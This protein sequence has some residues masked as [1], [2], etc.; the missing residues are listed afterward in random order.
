MAKITSTKIV[1]V[2]AFIGLGLVLIVLL[3]RL[4]FG[5]LIAT[6]IRT[7]MLVIGFAMMILGTLWK[8]VLDMNDQDASDSSSD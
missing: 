4:F 2:I 3:S 8:V 6:D 5:S 7:V 1:T